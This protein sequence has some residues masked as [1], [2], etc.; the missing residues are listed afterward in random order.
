MK[1]YEKL[2]MVRACYYYK[3][4]EGSPTL[5]RGVSPL[6]IGEDLQGYEPLLNSTQANTTGA[7]RPAYPSV[8]WV[9]ST[10]LKVVVLGLG[11]DSITWHQTIKV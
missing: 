5:K 3:R 7:L 1:K 10:N 4:N 9:E 8:A 11:D 6:L 2:N